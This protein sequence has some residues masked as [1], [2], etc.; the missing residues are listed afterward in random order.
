MAF[1]GPNERVPLTR[2]CLSSS[3]SSIVD[4]QTVADIQELVTG[5]IHELA[6]T[7]QVKKFT[8][9][10]ANSIYKEST[11]K[12]FLA[13]ISIQA[14]IEV[15]PSAK[16]MMAQGLQVEVDVLLTVSASDLTAINL[17]ITTDDRIVVQ[18]KEYNV[19]SVSPKSFVHN[20]PISYS[21]A[22]KEFSS[23]GPIGAV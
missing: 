8:T 12:Q 6:G 7:V 22:G 17:T 18:G 5:N 9:T 14:I 4:A 21:I 16:S 13:P 20:T 11:S 1:L 10:V 2:K 3:E 23:Q 15:N 19:Y